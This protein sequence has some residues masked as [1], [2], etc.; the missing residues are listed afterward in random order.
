MLKAPFLIGDFRLW[1]LDWGWRILD[2]ARLPALEAQL[3]G[4]KDRG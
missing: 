4:G 2:F 3:M 1:I